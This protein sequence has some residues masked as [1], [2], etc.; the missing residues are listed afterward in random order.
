MHNKEIKHYQITGHANA[1]LINNTKKALQ[2]FPHH[3]FSTFPKQTL[4][5]VHIQSQLYS[6]VYSS[7]FSMY[8]LTSDSIGRDKALGNERGKPFRNQQQPLHFFFF[9]LTFIILL[10]Y[11]TIKKRTF[12]NKEF[13]KK[14]MNWKIMKQNTQRLLMY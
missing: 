12:L 14:V 13:N 4:L 7:Y 3:N 2:L 8:Y 6:C 11:V 9:N 1:R 5:A 10:S